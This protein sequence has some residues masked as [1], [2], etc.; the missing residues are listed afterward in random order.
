MN[1][2]SQQITARIAKLEPR[3][4]PEAKDIIQEVKD[5]LNAASSLGVF[6]KIRTAHETRRCIWPGQSSDGMIHGLTAFPWDGTI[7]T[8]VPLAE[9]IVSDH[10]RIRMSALRAGNTQ[11]GPQEE[12]ADSQKAKQ[13]DG[14]L[15]YY[16]K[17]VK[18]NLANQFKL[19]FTC[20]EEIGYGIMHVDWR[21]QKRLKP[22]QA[23]RAQV[24]SLLAQ[25]LIA[26]Q[27]AEL[28]MD[29]ERM[30]PALTQQ[31][32]QDATAGVEMLL[33][34]PER[35]A[36]MMALLMQLDAAMPPSE[37]KRAI[38]ELRKTGAAT[39]YA[40]VSQGGTPHIR[41]RIPWVNCMHSI[42][43]GPDGETSF[44]ADVEKLTEVDLRIRAAQDGWSDEAME[45]VLQHPNK[46]CAE[47]MQAGT[48][49]GNWVLN[50]VGIGLE[51]EQNAGDR[52]PMF[53]I[54]TVHRLAV[55]EAGIPAVYESVINV[56]VPDH[57]LKH[58]CCDVAVMPFVVEQREPAALAVQ[59]RG[60]PEI[61]LTDQLALKKL[62]D[63]TTCSAELAG[64]P[65]YVNGIN[66]NQKLQPGAEMK[67]VRSTGNKGM[68]SHFIE[69]PGVD[70][71]ALKAMEMTRLDV[72]RLFCREKDSDPD[73][74]RMF[75]EDLG[76]SA[77]L[78]EEAV[79]VLIWLHVQAYVSNVTAS[80]IAGRPID[81]KA[82]ASDL[83]GTAD[84]NIEF[85]PM[86]LNQ[87]MAMELAEWG[88]KV[89]PMDTAGRIDRG[90]FI[91]TITRVFD[92]ALSERVILPGEVASAQIEK[93]E[94]DVIAAITSG[95]YITGH[96]NSP[97]QRFHVLQQWMQNPA[98]IAMLQQRPD[99]YA[100]VQEHIAGLTQEQEQ[101]TTNVAWGQTGQNP[102]PPWQEEQKPENALKAA[103][104][105][106]GAPMAR[107]A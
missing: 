38:K 95:Q 92:P 81:V 78:S 15:R 22:K 3:Q 77:V 48:A 23:T 105:G 45:A 63:A 33:T 59:S 103:V 25:Q 74:R 56:N 75:V 71:G 8:R 96:V 89:L 36:D 64:Y 29:P 51:I 55:N 17:S 106:G 30:A 53:E 62:K 18:R 47:L 49:G 27:A 69:V 101:H 93:D 11:I 104:E 58:E 88:T 57:L 42:D 10:V 79:I 13:W 28:Q 100:A 44:F 70:E 19:F 72:N 39:Y 97:Q 80:R 65:P 76:F 24:V 5:A 61:I 40:P 12:V 85:S 94:Q 84:I 102:I 43:L 31:A 26:D 90:E 37:A 107:A 21:D 2:S 60:I 83:E 32:A 1:P 86:A 82:S 9:E 87:K 99:V 52:T 34:D 41:A 67:P 16:R 66:D 50:G 98:T 14:V 91:E 54:V 4:K 7:D 68:D 73:R 46:G 6:D 35:E 20:V